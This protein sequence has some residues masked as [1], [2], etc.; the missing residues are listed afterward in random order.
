MK[1]PESSKVTHS[2][3]QKGTSQGGEEGF[4][5]RLLYQQIKSLKNGSQR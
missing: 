5:P 4:K 2:I 3:Q 1:F